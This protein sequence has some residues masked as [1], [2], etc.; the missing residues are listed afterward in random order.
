[1]TAPYR[2][3]LP[4]LEDRLFL[5]DGGLETTLVF[6]DGMD[7]PC[8]AS[9]PLLDSEAG[10]KRLRDYYAQYAMIAVREP[11]R[12]RPRNADMAGQSRLGQ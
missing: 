7:L 9:F 12:L 8:F 11:A 6:H 5:T 10:L 1:M 2:H 4:Q 3:R